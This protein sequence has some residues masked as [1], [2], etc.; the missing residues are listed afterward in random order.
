M[1]KTYLGHEKGIF[2]CFYVILSTT[3]YSSNKVI[4]SSRKIVHACMLVIRYEVKRPRKSFI[5]CKYMWKVL[6]IGSQTV[7]DHQGTA[8]SEHSRQ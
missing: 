8:H 3:T 1:C 6:L 5:K 4:R 7:V 2:D